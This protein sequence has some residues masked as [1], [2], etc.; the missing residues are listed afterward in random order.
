MKKLPCLPLFITFW[1]LSV[2]LTVK[3]MAGTATENDTLIYLNI[4]ERPEKALVAS[5]IVPRI[6]SLSLNNR[7]K[8][9]IHEFMNGNVPSFARKMRQI[10]ITQKIGT[11][12]YELL[13]FALCDYI[14]IGSDVNYLYTPLTPSAAQFIADQ[15]QCTLPTSRLVNVIYN[16]AELKLNPQPIPPSNQMTTVP[17]FRD[18]T[19]S[20]KQQ[21][22]TLGFD[23]A[24][25]SIVGG[26]KK[27]IIISNKI[28]STD[29]SYERVVI[30]G[31]HRSINDPIQPVYNGHNAQ[32]ADYSHG[33]R[34]IANLAF[35]NGD[36]VMVT[37]LMQDSRLSAL[38]SSEGRISTPYYPA[39]SVF[40]GMNTPDFDDEM[41]FQLHQN[42][43]NPFNPTT[44]IFYQLAK[45]MP[46]DLS[47][48][49]L[50]GQ[51][52]ATLVAQQQSAGSYHVA[53]DAFDLPSGTYI[54][55]LRTGVF[56]ESRKMLLVR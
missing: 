32:Y 13:L 16:A 27:D 19:D 9:I 43:P 34:L 35:L 10:K 45:A 50:L 24:S 29:R 30:Y 21:I 6:S 51:K 11:T 49:N 37:D 52:I 20:I 33:V 44:M 28:Y 2:Q 3:V 46:V 39:N 7:E 14:A 41:E 48:Y 25:D 54:Y 23:R 17:V 15:V 55:K 31:W 47:V 40:T 36:S 5:Q 56:E 12:D 42:Y 18:H 22:A 4:P 38:V 1:L 53:W 8:A 26:N